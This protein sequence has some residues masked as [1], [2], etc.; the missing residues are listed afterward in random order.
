MKYC[1]L[2]VNADVLKNLKVEW[3][4]ERRHA[5]NKIEAELFRRIIEYLDAAAINKLPQKGDTVRTD[6][7]KHLEESKFFA[8][9][10]LGRIQLH[11]TP[12]IRCFDFSQSSTHDCKNCQLVCLRLHN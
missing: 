2:T 11:G 4:V 9:E 10:I 6:C 12:V 1:K 5:F 7:M 8:T 3:T